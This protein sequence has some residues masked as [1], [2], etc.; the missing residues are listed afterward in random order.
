M[1]SIKLEILKRYLRD[2]RKKHCAAMLS[3]RVR[4]AAGQRKMGTSDALAIVNSN[5]H[6]A[7]SKPS[8]SMFQSTFYLY[9][10]LKADILRVLIDQG[11]ELTKTIY[12][13]RMIK[14]FQ[15]A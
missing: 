12:P 8:N 11:V 4:Q 15:N 1:N 14:L 3:F 10:N 2:E 13:K 7:F 5:V 6:L 9:K